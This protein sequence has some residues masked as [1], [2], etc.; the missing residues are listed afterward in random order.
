MIADDTPHT[1]K[2]PVLCTVLYFTV[3]P[4]TVLHSTAVPHCT[5]LY[6]NVL[7]CTVLYRTLPHCSALY[8]TAV[9]YCTLLYCAVLPL[10]A[11]GHAAARLYTTV[12]VWVPGGLRGA[13]S[14]CSML[15]NLASNN[16]V[17]FHGARA[18]Q[19]NA[20]PKCQLFCSAAA[21]DL[22]CGSHGIQQQSQIKF[23]WT[24]MRVCAVCAMIRVRVYVRAGLCIC[25]LESHTSA[26][27]YI[28][29]ACCCWCC[30]LHHAVPQALE[31]STLWQRWYNSSRTASLCGALLTM[32]V[33]YVC[34][35]TCACV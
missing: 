11:A 31:L 19:D 7:Y 20:K 21:Q 25:M 10:S 8:C 1:S 22:L 6:C 18:E 32:R 23:V 35:G 29:S 27:W 17:A 2:Y 26:F 28:C 5:A 15:R 4:C 12:Q 16:G 33:C 30:R 34:Y 13:C 3:L 24:T 14:G 9:H